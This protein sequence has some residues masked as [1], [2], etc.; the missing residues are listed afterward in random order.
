M[1]SLAVRYALCGFLILIEQY[2]KEANI[3]ALSFII[4]F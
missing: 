4:V 1:F 2:I 3:K